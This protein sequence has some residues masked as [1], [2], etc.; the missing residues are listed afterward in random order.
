MGERSSAYP[1]SSFSGSILSANCEDPQDDSVYTIGG[2]RWNFDA[3]P[4]GFYGTNDVWYSSN[5]LQWV[6]RTPARSPDPRREATCDVGYSHNIVVIGGSYIAPGADTVNYY[7]DVWTSNNKGTSWTRVTAR[8]PFTA[9]G[10]HAM[11]ITHSEY[12]GTDLIYVVGGSGLVSGTLTL[13]NDV[14]VSSN[15]GSQWTQ[16]VS[17][18]GWAGRSRFGVV[19]TSAGV[20]MLLGGNR[21]DVWASMNGGQQWRS[22]RLQ[23]GAPVI[24]GAPAIALTGDDKL[25]VGSGY[26]R[27]DLWTSDQSLKEPTLLARM[28]G[29]SIPEDGIG[30][31]IEGW[32]PYS[33]STDD[34]TDN[35][36]TS[37][38]GLPVTS[39]LLII[40]AVLA[41]LAVL[42]FLYRRQQ[43]TGSWNPMVHASSSSTDGL[44]GDTVNLSS[45]PLSSS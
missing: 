27:S 22:C 40:V 9:R 30:L 19:I 24:T 36:T 2:T 3:T 44:L 13:F 10:G 37:S 14:Y 6:K 38:S 33:N 39:I 34:P 11:Q 7:N 25:V 12:Y 41:V 21:N 18:G 4:P 5:A 23:A 8:A 16:V 31:R 20:M 1:T 42:Y 45:E 26:P 29:T 35:T 32:T 43:R 28:C 15:G 17:R